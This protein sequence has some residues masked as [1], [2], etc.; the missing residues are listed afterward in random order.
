[1]KADHSSVTELRRVVSFLSYL[2]VD[3]DTMQVIIDNPELREPAKKALV[4][5]FMTREARFLWSVFSHLNPSMTEI[6]RWIK[7]IGIQAFLAPLEEAE[8]EA[9]CHLYGLEGWERLHTEDVAVVMATDVAHVGRLE[10]RAFSKL[11]HPEHD[12]IDGLKHGGVMHG[13]TRNL[14]A[15]GS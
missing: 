8:R 6:F 10:S 14:L 15:G 5:S 4:G 12:L 9:I 2:G 13:P 7:N 3:N 1:M 11:R